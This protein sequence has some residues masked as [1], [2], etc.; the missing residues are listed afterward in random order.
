MCQEGFGV[1][2]G[3]ECPTRRAVIWKSGVVDFNHLLLVVNQA[4]VETIAVARV[5]D[6]DI[7]SVEAKHLVGGVHLVSG[8]VE[9]RVVKGDGVVIGQVADEGFVV[10]NPF[11]VRSEML[12]GRVVDQERIE[13]VWEG[14]LVSGGIH[15]FMLT[16]PLAKSTSI[17]E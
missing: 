12:V 16:R 11:E 5:D 7:P 13:A 4:V 6:A 2:A 15:D 9:H 8:E 14:G 17:S 10:R 1:V 3:G